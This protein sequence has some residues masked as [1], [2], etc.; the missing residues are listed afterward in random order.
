MLRRSSAML[1]Q[2]SFVIGNTGQGGRNG[3]HMSKKD[4]NDC[5]KQYGESTRK[6]HSK[7]SAMWAI[8]M[9]SGHTNRNMSNQSPSG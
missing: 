7:W 8:P 4:R 1:N 3:K 2:R 9:D 5:E 6:N